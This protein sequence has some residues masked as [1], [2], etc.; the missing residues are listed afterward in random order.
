MILGLSVIAIAFAAAVAGNLAGLALRH[1]NGSWAF[2]AAGF[3]DITLVQLTGV[4]QGVAFGALLLI[5]AAAIVAVLRP[6]LR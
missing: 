1:G 4:I 6:E 5:S 2:G 3:R